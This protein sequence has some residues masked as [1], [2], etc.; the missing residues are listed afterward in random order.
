LLVVIAATA[1]LFGSASPASAYSADFCG[2][3]V[4]S[5]G[6]PPWYCYSASARLSYSSSRYTGGG[7]VDYIYANL[8]G[9]DNVLGAG[10]CTNFISV[11]DYPIIT[12]YGRA[13]QFEFSGAS[14]TIYGHVDDSPNHTSCY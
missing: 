12:R 10:N 14:H 1:C 6:P 11:C 3:L 4:P 7:C 8:T 9:G 5:F 2:V 13:Q